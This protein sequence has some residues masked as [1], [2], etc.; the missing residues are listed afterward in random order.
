MRWLTHLMLTVASDIALIPTLFL[1]NT[2]LKG[3]DAYQADKTGLPNPIVLDHFRQILFDTPIFRCM[4][5]SLII[6]GGSVGLSLIVACLAAYAI[7]RMEFTRRDT[8]F[9]L[10]TALMAVPPVVPIF[11]M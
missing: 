4:A 11:V 5:N 7:A 9:A 1:I 6:A 10:S 2:A 8:L 3:K